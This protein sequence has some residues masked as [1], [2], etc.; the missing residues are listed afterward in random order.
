MV[1][2]PIF[3]ILLM[4][5]NKPGTVSRLSRVFYSV[6][7]RRLVSSYLV[8]CPGLRT[9][10]QRIRIGKSIKLSVP[11]DLEEGVIVIVT[12]TGIG[13]GAEVRIRAEMPPCSSSY[14]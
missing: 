14:S 1:Q 5:G 7:L 12:A 4:L 3:N 8:S 2:R 13:V 11:R 6:V 10:W 9:Y